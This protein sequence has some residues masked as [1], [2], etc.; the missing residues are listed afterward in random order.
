MVL[1]KNFAAATGNTRPFS[2]PTC[3]MPV[4]TSARSTGIATISFIPL[5]FAVTLFGNAIG[6]CWRRG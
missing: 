3:N 1:S 6:I 4:G 5:F 2:W